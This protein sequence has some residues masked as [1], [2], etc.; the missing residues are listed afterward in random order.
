MNVQHWATA[1]GP[2]SR[3]VAV[4]LLQAEPLFVRDL[5]AENWRLY[6]TCPSGLKL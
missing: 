2:L 1:E 6:G 3:P 5:N 4:G